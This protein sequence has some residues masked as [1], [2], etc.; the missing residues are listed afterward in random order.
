MY[1]CTFLDEVSHA[2]EGIDAIIPSML[3]EQARM[4]LKR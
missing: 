3:E 2:F 4:G 1:T